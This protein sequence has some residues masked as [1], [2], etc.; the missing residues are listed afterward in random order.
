MENKKEKE[1]NR[2][3]R[4]RF[5][6]IWKCVHPTLPLTF[7]PTI[8]EIDQ[9]IHVKDV[10]DCAYLTGSFRVRMALVMNQVNGT[11]TVQKH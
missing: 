1:K 11:N 3:R 9:S 6:M 4:L 8:L 5:I 2:K 7:V 10:L